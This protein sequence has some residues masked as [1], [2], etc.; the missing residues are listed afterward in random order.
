M[1]S[2][3]FTLDGQPVAA[4]P[5]MTLL[6]AAATVGI[7]IPHLCKDPRVEP[8]G[9]CRLCAVKIEG[10]PGLVTACSTPATEGLRVCSEDEELAAVRRGILELVLGEHCA[11]CTTCDRDGACKL[12][13]YAYRYQV[14]LTRWGVAA[15]R[16]EEP[17]YSSANHGIRYDA[18]KCIRCGLCVAY[19]QD[20]QMAGALTFA[21][22]VAEMEVSTAFG[23]DLHESDC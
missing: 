2:I 11:T 5:G 8:I 3:H 7:H 9:A 19:C 16:A 15:P 22:P 17:N 12:Q 14:D 4:A 1:E 20:V 6:E 23:I 13:D 10:R 18:S 21:G